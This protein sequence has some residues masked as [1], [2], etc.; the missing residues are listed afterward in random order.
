MNIYNNKLR[1]IN[2]IKFVMKKNVNGK[3]VG[4]EKKK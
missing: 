4:E 2:L 1:K 3:I